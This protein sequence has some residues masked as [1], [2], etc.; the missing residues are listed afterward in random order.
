MQSSKVEA[1]SVVIVEKVEKLDK[2]VNN[3]KQV[4][5]LVDK[6]L[7][8]NELGVGMEEVEI[9]SRPIEV[10][11][12]TKEDALHSLVGRPHGASSSGIT[13]ELIRL[14]RGQILS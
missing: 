1:N 11:E 7:K 12:Q 14:V 9:P 13:R 8:A 3:L 10:K 6:M 5:G 4:I 2:K